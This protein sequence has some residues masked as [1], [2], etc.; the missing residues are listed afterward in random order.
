M[1]WYEIWLIEAQMDRVVFYYTV[2][3]GAHAAASNS[4]ATPHLEHLGHHSQTHLSYLTPLKAYTPIQ[5][6]TS[7]SWPSSDFLVQLEALA[8]FIAKLQKLNRNWKKLKSISLPFQST[9]LHK[10]DHF[11]FQCFGLQANSH[12]LVTT[13]LLL[14]LSRGEKSRACLV[15][16]L[17][18]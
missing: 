6:L 9:Q 16:L 14:F 17:Y 12:G 4:S 3:L 1:I 5:Q 15:Q 18:N 11:W 7:V 10:N 8:S 13:M 2:L